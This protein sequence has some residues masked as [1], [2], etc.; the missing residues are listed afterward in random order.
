MLC[1]AKREL[2]RKPFFGKK[3]IFDI[4]GRKHKSS[5]WKE[6]RPQLDSLTKILIYEFYFKLYMVARG[7]RGLSH[8]QDLKGLHEAPDSS[9]TEERQLW[10]PSRVVARIK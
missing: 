8:A 1:L 5:P 9:S 4:S 3:L 7:I 2:R 6:I 10:H